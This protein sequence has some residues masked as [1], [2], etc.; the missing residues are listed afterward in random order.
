MKR[1]RIHNLRISKTRILSLI[2][3]VA[4][5]LL[6]SLIY[7]I[8]LIGFSVINL[9]TP[10]WTSKIIKLRSIRVPFF[11]L[12]V[13]HLP[14]ALKTVLK[15]QNELQAERDAFD[16]FIQKMNATTPV[17]QPPPLDSRHCIMNSTWDG[18]ELKEVRRAYQET[19][20]AVQHYEKEYDD[21]IVQSLA[22]EFGP[23]IATQLV[24]GQTY[25]PIIKKHLIEAAKQSRQEREHLLST[26]ESEQEELRKAQTIIEEIDVQ[27]ERVSVS[28]SSDLS[29]NELFQRCNALTDAEKRCEAV[30]KERQQQRIDGH[31]AVNAP[32]TDFTDLYAYLYSSLSVTYPILAD[33]TELLE[34]L[35]RTQ[36]RLATKLS[37]RL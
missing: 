24:S 8:P 19:V 36:E 28:L 14:E 34:R 37:T 23:E 1:G 30:L 35:Q 18:T 12:T 3:C 26:I 4:L 25:T 9:P 7:H 16:A 31:G 22:E 27:I 32:Q 15:E 21:M 2:I 29:V 33:T 20:M 11:I 17:H 13:G 5:G 10:N 6:A